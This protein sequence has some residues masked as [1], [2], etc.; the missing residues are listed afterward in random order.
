MKFLFTVFLGLP[1]YK[2]ENGF[3]VAFLNFSLSTPSS[4]DNIFLSLEG[5]NS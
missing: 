2:N 1:T 4:D 3:F 5:G